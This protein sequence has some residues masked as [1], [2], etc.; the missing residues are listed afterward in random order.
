MCARRVGSCAEFVAEPRP[1][2]WEEGVFMPRCSVGL[3]QL[4]LGAPSLACVGTGLKGHR[5]CAQGPFLLPFL[6]F[7]HLNR[8]DPVSSRF[9]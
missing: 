4:G 9:L 3:R 7:V 1:G 6:P 5:P 2:S 8:R